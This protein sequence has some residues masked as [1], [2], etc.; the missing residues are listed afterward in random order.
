[1]HR[2]TKY[3]Y[4]HTPVT[5]THGLKSLHTYTKYVYRHTPVTAMHGLK[6]LHTYVQ[7]RSTKPFPDHGFA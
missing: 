4:R 1:M 3:V 2:H 7:T 6:S 5:A